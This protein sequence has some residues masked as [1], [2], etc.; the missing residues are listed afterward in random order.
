MVPEAGDGE[1][2]GGQQA[3]AARGEVGSV[4]EITAGVLAARLPTPTRN[5]RTVHWWRSA[6]LVLVGIYALVS[7][8]GLVTVVVVLFGLG[9]LWLALTEALAAL[10]APRPE[11]PDADASDAEGSGDSEDSDPVEA[12]EATETADA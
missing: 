5:A 8:G 9:L 7:P 6:V 11:R 2:A 4:Q 12:T 1:V 3:A 10:A